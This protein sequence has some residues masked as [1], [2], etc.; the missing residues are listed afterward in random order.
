MKTEFPKTVMIHQRC[1]DGTNI[2]CDGCMG[3]AFRAIK[4]EATETWEVEFMN[5]ENGLSIFAF[6]KHNLEVIA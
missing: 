3:I 6:D 2:E 5:K 1:V 4:A